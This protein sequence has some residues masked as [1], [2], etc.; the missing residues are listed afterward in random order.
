[1]DLGKIGEL[2]NTMKFDPLKFHLQILSIWACMDL[3][4]RGIG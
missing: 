3:G 2:A 4:I 1:M